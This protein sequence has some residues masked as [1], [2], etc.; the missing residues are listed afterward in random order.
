MASPEI[1]TFEDFWPYYLGAHRSAGC[2]ALH[3]VGTTLAAGTL[4]TAVLT[5]NPLLL[6][7]VPVVGY[8]PSWIGHFFIEGNKPATF[9]YPLYSLR[10]D[11]RMLRLALA[12]KMGAE[13]ERLFPVEVGAA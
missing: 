6:L 7:A 9:G 11:F 5:A 10:G 12:G 8:G 3:Y 1:R 2:R 13:L 4:A